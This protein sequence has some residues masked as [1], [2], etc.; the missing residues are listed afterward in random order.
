MAIKFRIISPRQKSG[1]NS[2]P[3][4]QVLAAIS[5]ESGNQGMFYWTFRSQTT[6]LDTIGRIS[7]GSIS[8]SGTALD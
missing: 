5:R 8:F 1:G 4:K 6:M 3:S 2:E 7:H